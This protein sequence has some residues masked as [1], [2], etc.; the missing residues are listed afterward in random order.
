MRTFWQKH[1]DAER[2][3]RNWIRITKAAAWDSFADVRDSFR[4]ADVFR[5]CVIFDVGG[6]NYRLTAKINYQAKLVFVRHVMT[7]KEYDSDFWKN[8]CEG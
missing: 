6:N 7:H 8:G 4:A 2:P 5:R 1:P 3:L